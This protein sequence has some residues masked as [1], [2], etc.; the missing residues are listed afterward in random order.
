ME[1]KNRGCDTSFSEGIHNNCR[2]RRGRGRGAAAGRASAERL[3][4]GGPGTPAMG[5]KPLHR[6]V[7]PATPPCWLLPCAGHPA[8]DGAPMAAPQPLATACRAWQTDHRP[9]QCAEPDAPADVVW[10]SP[11]SARCCESRHR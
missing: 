6:P 5:P 9:R 1:M 2:I 8:P 3:L 7:G 4:T 11:G 10:P